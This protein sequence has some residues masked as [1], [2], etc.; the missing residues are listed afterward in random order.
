MNLQYN[1]PSVAKKNCEARKAER[2]LSRRP[3]PL[4]ADRLIELYGAPLDDWKSNFGC[5]VVHSK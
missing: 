1:M 5:D 3:A 4:S 2:K